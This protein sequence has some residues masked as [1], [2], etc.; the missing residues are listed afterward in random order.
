MIKIKKSNPNLHDEIS[1]KIYEIDTTIPFSLITNANKLVSLE[2]NDS[3]LSAS[4]KTK[5]KEYTD[6]LDES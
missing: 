1:K 6:T 4:K 2:I 3:K 5:L